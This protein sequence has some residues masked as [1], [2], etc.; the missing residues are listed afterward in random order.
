MS[1]IDAFMAAKNHVTKLLFRLCVPAVSYGIFPLAKYYSAVTACVYEKCVFSKDD[2]KE[3]EEFED[4]YDIRPPDPVY[5]DEYI[6]VL[7][8]LGTRGQKKK[9][10]K[11][12]PSY[13]IDLNGT[14]YSNYQRRTKVLEAY[15]FKFATIMAS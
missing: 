12:R 10:E 6:D 3:D 2:E 8:D 13:T 7:A 15:L 5:T 1:V 9:K 14:D 4:D 11:V